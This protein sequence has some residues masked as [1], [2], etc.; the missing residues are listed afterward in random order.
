MT[1]AALI[2]V[3]LFLFN[4]PAK[5]DENEYFLNIYGGELTSNNWEDFLN[6]FREL[7]FEGT[8]LTALTLARRI[9]QHKKKI[10]FEIE[11]QIVKHFEEQHHWEFNALGTAR[12]EPFPWDSVLDTSVAFGL[13][14][15]YA[16][17]EP[18]TEIK[19]EG[20]TKKLMIYWMIELALFFP[21]AP[22][23]AVITRIHHRSEAYGLVAD[24]GGSNVLA[25]GVKYSF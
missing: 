3:T 20:S 13:G 21:D 9:G 24:E 11:G 22:K 5:A 10:S 2:I 16:T 8:Y 12:W 1:Q 19:N 15:S 7:D 25:L 14:P 23:W 17:E 4:S 18:P 6:P